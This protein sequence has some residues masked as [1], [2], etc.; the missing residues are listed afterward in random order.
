MDWQHQLGLLLVLLLTS[1]GAAG[2]S[3]AALPV[4]AITLAASNT[5]PVASIALIIGVHRFLAAAFVFT[6]ITGNSVATI[7]VAAW[8]N[9]LDRNRLKSELDNGYVATPAGAEPLRA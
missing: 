3:G 9:A 7:V 4:L 5:I 1:K 8:E 6:N 2:V